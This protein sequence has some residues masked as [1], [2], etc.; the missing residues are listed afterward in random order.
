MSSNT[1]VAERLQRIADLLDLKAEKFKPEAYRRAARSILGLGEDLTAF[2]S[3]GQLDEI[4]GVGEAIRKKIE[5]Y[6]TTGRIGYLERLT[7]EVPPGVVELMGLPGLG[8]KTA[9]R[10]FGELGVSSPAELGD[11]IATGRLNGLA[12]FGPK[13]IALLKEA[14]EGARAVSPARRPLREAW[15]IAERIRRALAERTEVRELEIAGSLRRRRETIG[16]IDLLA[17]STDP[18]ATI[19][20]FA[21]L[22]EVRKVVMKGPTKCTVV[23]EPGVQ[24]DLRVVAPGSFGAALQY[25]TGSKD[26]NI[27]LRTRARDLG[28]KINEYGVDRGEVRVGGRD[29]TEV[30]AALGLPWIPPE[31][32]ED[33]GELE[34]AAAG[35]LPDLIEAGQIRGTLHHHLPPGAEEAELAL[36]ARE[37]ARQG[38]AYVGAVLGPGEAAHPGDLAGAL[39]RAWA[40]LAVVPRPRLLIGLELSIEGASP[41]DASRSDF[42]YLVL[43]AGASAP[44]VGLRPPQEGPPRFV[45]HL[46]LDPGGTATPAERATPWIRWASENRVALEVTPDGPT[47]GL[48]SNG[49]RALVEVGGEIVVSPGPDRGALGLAVGLARRGWATSR[50]VLNARDPPPPAPE[51]SRPT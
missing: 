38:A 21:S 31:I 42:D 16:D 1:E 6:L 39:R 8:P 33:R 10:L 36:L 5:E 45:G 19:G 49:I 46:A 13:K 12:G 3:R 28:L 15:T 7:A 20:V 4:P 22:P 32:R 50:H 41:G 44:R 18:P 47:D 24:V 48:D 23:V 40:Q 25:F 43:R 11:A 30:Y 17:T 51:R 29:E 2:R 9:A 27:K 35:E 34:A 37:G 14:A 26:H